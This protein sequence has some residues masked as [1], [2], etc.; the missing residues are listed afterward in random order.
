MSGNGA[1]NSAARSFAFRELAVATRGF[2]EVNLIGEGGFGRVFKGR[3]ETGQ[4][5]LGGS[6][7]FFNICHIY[8]FEFYYTAFKIGKC[9]VDCAIFFNF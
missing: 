1:K 2:K 8:F 6:F 3:L 9:F 7:Y 4:V 5:N